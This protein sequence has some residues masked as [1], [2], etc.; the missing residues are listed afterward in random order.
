MEKMFFLLLF[1]VPFFSFCQDSVKTSNFFDDLTLEE[2]KIIEAK[3]KNDLAANKRQVSLLAKE[4]A[5]RAAEINLRKAQEA[6]Q[7]KAIE[8]TKAN[9]TRAKE[10]ADLQ[11]KNQR[12]ARKEK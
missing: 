4:G 1:L 8:N 7:V 11:A 12:D 6:A 9:A 2:R 3:K 5:V 10:L